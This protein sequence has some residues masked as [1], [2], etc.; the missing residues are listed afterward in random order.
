MSGDQPTRE[1][2]QKR[3]TVKIEQTNADNEDL[4]VGEIMRFLSDDHT[5]PGGV[6]VELESGVTGRVQRIAPDK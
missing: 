3:M 4:L 1:D 2:L 5:Q 6:E